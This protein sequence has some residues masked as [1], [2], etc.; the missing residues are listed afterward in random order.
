MARSHRVAGEGRDRERN[1][2]ERPITRL[3][4]G[5]RIATRSEK[6]ATTDAAMPTVAAIL[7]WR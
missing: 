6:R 2:G 1:R 5:R 4:Q 7:L 3:E